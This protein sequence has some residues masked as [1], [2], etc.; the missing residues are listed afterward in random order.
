MSPEQNQNSAYPKRPFCFLSYARSTGSA[1]AKKFADDLAQ[2]LRENHKF[3]VE[4]EPVFFDQNI[5]PGSVWGED[6]ERGLKHSKVMVSLVSE[7]YFQSEYC[8]K[9][10]QVFRSRRDNYKSA[11]NL[12]K[13]PGL[14]VP[15]RWLPQEL[16]GR[17]IPD[18]VT[19]IQYATQEWGEDYWKEG[20]LYL[21]KNEKYSTQYKDF[22]HALSIHL[23]KVSREHPL[24]SLTMLG[25]LQTV[26]SATGFGPIRS[27]PFANK[28]ENALAP[29]G[30]GGWIEFV[31]VAATQKEAEAFTN[32]AAVYDPK[33]GPFWR[34]YLPPVD[35]SIGEITQRVAYDE[36]FVSNVLSTNTPLLDYIRAAKK[37]NNLLIIVVDC[38]SLGLDTYRAWVHSFDE[39]FSANCEMLIPLNGADPQFLS[40][41]AQIEQLLKKTFPQRTVTQGLE[42]FAV[43]ATS[44]KQLR[45]KL[46]DK[47][48][49]MRARITSLKAQS[50]SNPST[51][52]PFPS[53]S[54]PGE[55]I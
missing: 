15:V 24:E 29:S 42:R 26:E 12:D 31:Y 39:V 21:I 38:W 43:R 47:I 49:E 10:F 28:T 23:L 7:H 37:S 13:T 50:A 20:L 55:R 5:E 8:G 3:G 41:K 19:E 33:G 30:D 6:I 2:D 9:E 17:A 4:E 52:A 44:E 45:R 18:S 48:Q 51:P 53:I 22:V 16:L 25:E 14:I 27:A 1:Y 32:Q 40:G 35:R 54:G 11:K 46:A 34:P 36:R